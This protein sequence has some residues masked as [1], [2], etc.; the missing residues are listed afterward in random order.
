MNSSSIFQQDMADSAV[1]LLLS[2]KV[3]QKKK[4]RKVSD[5][6]IFECKICNK[7]FQS[8]Q[9]LGGHS[10]SHKRQKI[11]MKY[12][13]HNCSVCGMEFS[14]GQSLGGHM[15]RHKKTTDSDSYSGPLDLKSSACN[16]PRL[17]PLFV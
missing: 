1:D 10:T 7:Q 13:G 3:D 6:T 11:Q 9:A 8:F 17:L 12:R 2:L 14:S 5:E 4:K 15:K 16:V